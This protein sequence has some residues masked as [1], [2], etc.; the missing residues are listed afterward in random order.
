[1]TKKDSDKRKLIGLFQRWQ[2]GTLDKWDVYVEARHMMDRRLV[3]LSDVIEVAYNVCNISE[4]VVKMRMRYMKQL[5]DQ[6]TRSYETLKAKGR[7]SK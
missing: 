4:G 3:K 1:M 7:L 6:V 5:G 2:A